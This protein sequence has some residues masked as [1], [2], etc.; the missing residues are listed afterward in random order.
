MH[1]T[2]L[3]HTIGWDE[4]LVGMQVGGE[5]TLTIPP[6]LAYGKRGSAPDI[7]ANATLIFGTITNFCQCCFA[8]QP[9]CRSET[10]RGQLKNASVSFIM[11]TQK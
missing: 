3:M 7:P 5:R 1:R 4:G 9:P 10:P 6:K 2:L 8:N 11:F